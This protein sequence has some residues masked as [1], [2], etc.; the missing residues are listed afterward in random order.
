MEQWVLPS[1]TA[2]VK[3]PAQK[4]QTWSANISASRQQAQTPKHLKPKPLNAV[5]L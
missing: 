4:K 3:G 5:A 1:N 2:D